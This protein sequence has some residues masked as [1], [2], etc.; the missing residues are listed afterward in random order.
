MPASEKQSRYGQILVRIF[1]QKYVAG[2]EAVE[3]DRADIPAACHYLGIAQPKNLGDVV[4]S[5]RYR[6][7]MPQEIADRAPAGKT[8]ILV[9]RGGAKYAFVAIPDQPL[10]PNPHMVAIKVPDATPGIIAKYAL[11][12]EQALLAKVRYNRLIDLFT[13]IVCYSLQNH[14]RSNVP[15][16]GQTE[17]DEIYLGIDKAGRQYVIPVEAKAGSDRLSIVQMNQDLALAKYKFGGLE[18]RLVGAQFV[19]EDV[20]LFL[21]A[22]DADSGNVKVVAER[23]YVLVPPSAITDDDLRSYREQLPDV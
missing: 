11:S 12:S 19:G 18:I 10:T 22:E 8:W 2:A 3:F 16:I 4:Y 13:G 23:R 1:L 14:L 6:N 7:D 5:Y 21:F 15:D 17:T 20:A 9:G